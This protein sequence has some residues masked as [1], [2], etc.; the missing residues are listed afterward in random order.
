[1]NLVNL[2]GLNNL[3][4]P[5]PSRPSQTPSFSFHALLKSSTIRIESVEAESPST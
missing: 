4:M 2:N 5:N 3:K 1:M